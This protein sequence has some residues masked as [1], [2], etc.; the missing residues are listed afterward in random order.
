[1]GIIAPYK[2]PGA[3]FVMTDDLLRFL[4]TVI[5][6]PGERCTYDVFLKRLYSHYGIAVEG[7]ALADSLLW[8]GLPANSSI[9]P[10]KGSWF[11]EMLRAGGF[12]MQ[13]SDA[14]S[15]VCNTFI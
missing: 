11:A 14:C 10:M 12:L 13:L 5:L 7:G 8:S 4:V 3:R 15:I 2:G 9:Q 6:Y 1:M